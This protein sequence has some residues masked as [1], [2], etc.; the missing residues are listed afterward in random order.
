MIMGTLRESHWFNTKTALG[1]GV[2]VV[3]VII[4]VEVVVSG[5]V[6]V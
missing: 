2:V 1:A 3:V 4:V 6:H 5:S